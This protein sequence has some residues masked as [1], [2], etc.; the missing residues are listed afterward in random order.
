MLSVSLIKTFPCIDSF[1]GK[2]QPVD[3]KQKRQLERVTAEKEHLSAELA[4]IK[5]K[6]MVS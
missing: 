4:N 5:G 2:L 6:M 3:N 1:S